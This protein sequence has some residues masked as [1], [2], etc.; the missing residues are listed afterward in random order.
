M[1]SRPAR[2][3][4]TSWRA[5]REYRCE[6]ERGR[7]GDPR[8]EAEERGSVV[9]CGSSRGLEGQGDLSLGLWTTT[10]KRERKCELCETANGQLGPARFL[11]ARDLFVS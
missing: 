6:R 1:S 9:C 4:A 2:A 11:V 7:S 10:E 5:T 8:E 3:A